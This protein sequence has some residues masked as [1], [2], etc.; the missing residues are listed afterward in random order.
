MRLLPSL[1]CSDDAHRSTAAWTRLA[2][3]ERD[4]LGPDFGGRVGE[5]RRQQVADLRDVGLSGGAAQQAIVPDA[6]ESVGKDVDQ[7]TADEPVSGQP[8]DLLA[9]ATLVAIAL[10]LEDDGVCVGTD[11]AVVRYGD[12]VGVSAQVGQH[13]LGSAARVII[14]SADARNSSS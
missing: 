1:E 2:Q 3:G 8:H 12:A 9:I 6:V 4:G 7:E 14:V 13:R 11:Q 5:R 10:P